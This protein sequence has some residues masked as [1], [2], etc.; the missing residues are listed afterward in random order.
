[1]QRR[2]FDV[3]DRNMNPASEIHELMLEQSALSREVKASYSMITDGTLSVAFDHRES[4][5]ECRFIREAIPVE[6]FSVRM[7][8]AIFL[9]TV[10]KDM[11]LPALSPYSIRHTFQGALNYTTQNA[12]G[13]NQEDDQLNEAVMFRRTLSDFD[14]YAL[15]NSIEET[16]V[17]LQWKQEVAE[18]ASAPVLYLG[19]VLSAESHYFTKYHN[20]SKPNVPQQI[21][22]PDADEN[23]RR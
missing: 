1:M 23:I 10:T 20:V 17:F 14:M 21:L 13:E 6:K 11:G 18:Q 12:W 2:D 16:E 3:S 7:V 19:T 15:N 4:C 9:Y 8:V 22:P 5:P